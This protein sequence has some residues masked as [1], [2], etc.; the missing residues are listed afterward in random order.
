MNTNKDILQRKNYLEGKRLLFICMC[1][2]SSS[3]CATIN[4]LELMRAVDLA[5]YIHILIRI[6][7]FKQSPNNAIL[8]KNN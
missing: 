2:E 4:L 3:K 1:E 8:K 6:V 5:K 7:L